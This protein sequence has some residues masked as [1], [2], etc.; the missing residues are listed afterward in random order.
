MIKLELVQKGDLIRKGSGPNGA[1]EGLVMEI[2]P[3]GEN[4]K[5][6]DGEPNICTLCFHD[7]Y[8]GPGMQKIDPEEE[9][10]VIVGAERRNILQRM[11]GE[12]YGAIQDRNRDLEFLMEALKR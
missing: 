2:D 6:F 10:E 5:F 7:C 12:T 8:H 1:V 11:V 4:N 3:K 9:C